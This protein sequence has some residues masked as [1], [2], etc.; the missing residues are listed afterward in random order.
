MNNLFVT[1][2]NTLLRYKRQL[3]LQDSWVPLWPYDRIFLPNM[4]ASEQESTATSSTLGEVSG[5]H[6]TLLF[7]NHV[8]R[9]REV[10]LQ[11]CANLLTCTPKPQYNSLHRFALTLLQRLRTCRSK[12]S[13]LYCAGHS[14]ESASK[15]GPSTSL[16]PSKS[17]GKPKQALVVSRTCRTD[18]RGCDR[19]SNAFRRRKP[20][21]RLEKSSRRA[22]R[23][24]PNWSK[25]RRKNLSLSDRC[26]KSSCQPLTLSAKYGCPILCQAVASICRLLYRKMTTLI[27]KMNATS[28][29]LTGCDRCSHLEKQH[30][31]R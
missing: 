31:R 29:C 15:E 23:V 28:L 2:A 20:R 30:P 18:T 1:P 14:N 27:V 26:Y 5:T 3:R 17:S 12:T 9:G 13:L 11:A 6:D 19:R 21:R 16:K 7:E 4:Q 22:T 24:R 25:R 8:T 10:A